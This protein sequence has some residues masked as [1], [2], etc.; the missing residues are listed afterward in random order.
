MESKLMEVAHKNWFRLRSYN[1][2]AD[3]NDVRFVNVIKHT[4][5]QKKMLLNSLYIYLTIAPL[6]I[7]FIHIIHIIQSLESLIA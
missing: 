6:I 1:L 2:L 7:V 4:P 3:G 5:Y